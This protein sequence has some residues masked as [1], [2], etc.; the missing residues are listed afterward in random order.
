MNDI[1]LV[2]KARKGDEHALY[3]LI[4]GSKEQLYRIAYSY[5]KS[6]QDALEAIQEVTYRAFKSIRKLKEDHYF[7]TWL[8]R[9]MINY[10]NDELRKR[11][12]T[13][14]SSDVGSDLSV[15]Q[16][17]DRFELEEAIEAL[18][19][20]T[21]EVL[22]LKYFEDLKIKEIAEVLDCPEGTVKTWLNKGLRKLRY[23]LEG[24]L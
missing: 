16:N 4:L 17:Q 5:L 20:P 22:K 9:I 10:C 19:S 12:R 24:R 18:E 8:I 21:K 14:P 11:K 3:S 2:K 13:I 1:D 15:T 7:S 23:Q 6:E